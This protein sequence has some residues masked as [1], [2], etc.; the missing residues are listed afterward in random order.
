MKVRVSYLV[1]VDDEFRRRINIYYGR[2]GLANRDQIKRWFEM[3]GESMNQDM[4]DTEED[5]WT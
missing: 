3:Y 5:K 2:P 4:P 1:E